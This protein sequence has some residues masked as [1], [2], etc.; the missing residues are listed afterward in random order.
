MKRNSDGTQAGRRALRLLTLFTERSSTLRLAA[1]VLRIGASQGHFEW[2]VSDLAEEGLA[3]STAFHKFRQLFSP[4]SCNHA[5]ASNTE[6]YA[7]L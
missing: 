4:V 5:S 6:S 1:L 3:A 2:L 7:V